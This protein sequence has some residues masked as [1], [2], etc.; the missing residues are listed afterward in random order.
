MRTRVGHHPRTT[1]DE[2]HAVAV[3]LET[4]T[5]WIRSRSLSRMGPHHR[6]Y[7]ARLTAQGRYAQSVQS[8]YTE[9]VERSLCWGGGPGPLLVDHAASVMRTA[10]GRIGGVLQTG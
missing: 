10:K 4:M 6:V 8:R 9:P 1:S 7:A 5:R 2:T 3:S